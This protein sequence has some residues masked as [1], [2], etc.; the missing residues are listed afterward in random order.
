MCIFSSYLVK[1][2]PLNTKFNFGNQALQNGVFHQEMFLFFISYQNRAIVFIS[3]L[4]LNM[5]EN[6]LKML[7]FILLGWKLAKPNNGSFQQYY[8]LRYATFVFIMNN[9]VILSKSWLFK[10]FFNG[11]RVRSAWAYFNYS[12]GYPLPP[13]AFT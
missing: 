9:T 1:L 10:I 7:E 11:G 3:W 2:F 5:V 13:T 8:V 6:K 4:S 12:T